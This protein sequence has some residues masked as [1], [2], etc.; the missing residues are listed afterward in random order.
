MQTRESK[1]REHGYPLVFF[2]LMHVKEW[3]KIHLIWERA[4]EH[5]PGLI[6]KQTLAYWGQPAFRK[7]NVVFMLF[8]LFYLWVSISILSAVRFVLFSSS[9]I[10]LLGGYFMHKQ[11]QGFSPPVSNEGELMFPFQKLFPPMLPQRD[12][13]VMPTMC[14][15][16]Y[17]L[18]LKW[19]KERQLVFPH[20]FSLQTS[21][22]GVGSRGN[23]YR[24]P[25]ESAASLLSW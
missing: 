11:Q 10:K 7:S 3:Q 16:W 1:S 22:S 18:P 9:Q 2:I 25:G 21:N 8:C 15:L 4:G 20:G 17:L 13:N 19:V 23:S 5:M 6:R 24:E 14:C 12:L